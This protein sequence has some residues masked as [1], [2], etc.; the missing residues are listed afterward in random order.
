MIIIRFNLYERLQI[1][2]HFPSYDCRENVGINSESTVGRNFEKDP[3]I[4]IRL[5][6]LS[7][8]L[9]PKRKLKI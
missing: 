1:L 5:K 8:N 6:Y 9:Q 2:Q 7:I 4:Y 3:D